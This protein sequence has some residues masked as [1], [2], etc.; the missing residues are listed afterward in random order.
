MIRPA[1]RAEGELLSALALRSKASWEYAA[2]L[3][4]AFREELTLDDEDVARARVYELKGRPAGFYS[5]EPITAARVELGH[6]FVEPQQQRRGIGRAMMQD[7]LARSRGLGFRAMIIQGD[8]HAI[9]F[10][11]RMGARCIGE[12]RSASVASRM[13][14]LFEIDI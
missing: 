5:L 2:D 8:P 11:E 10:Y 9:G 13:L 3:V 4:T 14:P 7:A 1:H 6:L 12:R